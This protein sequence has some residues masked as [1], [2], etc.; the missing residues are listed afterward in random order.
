MK[1]ST[2][3]FAVIIILILSVSCSMEWLYSYISPY[4]WDSARVQN[5][6]QDCETLALMVYAP[7]PVYVTVDDV[8][9]SCPWVERGDWR[10]IECGGPS[11]SLDPDLIVKIYEGKGNTDPDPELGYQLSR[12]KG[13]QRDLR[14]NCW[15]AS[16]DSH[17]T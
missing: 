14:A 8:D 5:L 10:R 16:L 17:L 13:R 2:G 9:F 15:L 4:N 1:R 3:I 7:H 6:S 12:S 11:S